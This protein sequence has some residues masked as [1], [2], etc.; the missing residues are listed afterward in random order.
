MGNTSSSH[1]YHI[2]SA[3]QC[4]RD[5]PPQVENRSVCIS[6]SISPHSVYIVSYLKALWH[7][8]AESCMFEGDKIQ[9][10]MSVYC[11]PAMCGHVT[12]YHVIYT[13]SD[14]ADLAWRTSRVGVRRAG[15]APKMAMCQTMDRR[16]TRHLSVCKGSVL[17][18]NAHTKIAPGGTPARARPAR[19][20]LEGAP[21]YH[22]CPPCCTRPAGAPSTAGCGQ[23]CLGILKNT[24]QK[25]HIFPN[26]TDHFINLLMG[27]R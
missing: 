14:G 3:Y 23:W 8:C 20:E 11:S 13:S 24:I 21:S 27:G 15:A 19:R 22:S 5:M 12:T 10:D 1:I 4:R 6:A 7:I 2:E 9:V 26:T 25:S 16:M 18:Q 17:P